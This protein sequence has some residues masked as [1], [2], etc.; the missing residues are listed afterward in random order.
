MPR[1]LSIIAFTKRERHA[2]IREVAETIQDSGGWILGHQT[3]SN[4]A[5]AISFEIR[6]SGLSDFLDR[7][8]GLGV[9][10]SKST[11]AR[12]RE[13]IR[14]IGT[15]EIGS[16]SQVPGNIQITFFHD[17]PDLRLEAPRIPG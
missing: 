7:L 16:S 3:F 12:V 9:S 2:V 17:E 4:K 14:G 11:A 13:R 15:A 5:I 10:V 8:A 1:P 6:A